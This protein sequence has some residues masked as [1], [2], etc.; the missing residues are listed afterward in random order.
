MATS[1]TD[2]VLSVDSAS[3]VKFVF[4]RSGGAIMHARLD[5]WSGAGSDAAKRVL[6]LFFEDSL[7]QTESFTRELASG[8]YSC[9]FKVFVVEDLNGQY[10]WTHLV[11]DTPVVTAA[12]DVNTGPATG[13]SQGFRDEYVLD[14]A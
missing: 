5:V 1:T 9:I 14:V 7:D 11:G 12:G 10:D 4:T 8:V 13:E 2:E 6:V 3:P